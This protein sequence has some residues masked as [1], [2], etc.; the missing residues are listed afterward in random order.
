MKTKKI[1]EEIKGELSRL[2]WSL[3]D[4]VKTYDKHCKYNSK[5]TDESFKKQLS[6]STT[7]PNLLEGYL[8][9]IHS[10]DQWQ[11]LG[12]I[13]PCFSSEE[14]FE[15]ETNIEMKNISKLISNSIK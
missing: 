7:N 12:M 2:S 9:F 11:R 10:H 6:R 3:S 1:Q 15:T 4:F 8:N 13:R 14:E 5:L